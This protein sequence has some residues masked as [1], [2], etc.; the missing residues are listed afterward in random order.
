LTHR[1]IFSIGH[2]GSGCSQGLAATGARQGR[3][4]SSIGS[5]SPV[6]PSYSNETSDCARVE[7]VLHKASLD[8]CV[9]GNDSGSHCGDSDRVSR[10]EGDGRVCI[11]DG[12][13]GGQEGFQRGKRD[14]DLRYRSSVDGEDIGRVSQESVAELIGVGVLVDLCIDI[15]FDADLFLTGGETKQ[16]SDEVHNSIGTGF[17]FGALWLISGSGS[18]EL[19]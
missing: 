11:G 4:E 17:L 9:A 18:D 2:S 1:S 19:E 5:G 14:E 8:F 3:D 6:V 12:S 13:D 10:G 15:I 16:I 7:S